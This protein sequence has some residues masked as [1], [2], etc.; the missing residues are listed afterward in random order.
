MSYMFPQTELSHNDMDLDKNRPCKTG[1]CYSV[2]RRRHPK[3]LCEWDM[4]LCVD[5]CE[6]ASVIFG[7]HAEEEWLECC[8]LHIPWI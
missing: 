1:V 7:E 6:W 5:V 8:L 2:A 4:C 3:L